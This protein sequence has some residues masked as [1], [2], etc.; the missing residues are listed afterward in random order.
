MRNH[1]HVMIVCRRF[2]PPWNDGIV[3]YAH[4]MTLLLT[5]L[6][7]KI[8]V[9]TDIWRCYLEVS[10]EDLDFFKCLLQRI[11]SYNILANFTF[12]RAN[13]IF[14]TSSLTKIIRIV[15]DKYNNVMFH[16]FSNATTLLPYVFPLV[17]KTLRSLRNGNGIHVIFHILTIPKVR[18]L[19]VINT[20][21]RQHKGLAIAVSDE[22][23]RRII[24][25]TCQHD[26]SSIWTLRPAIILPKVNLISGNIN[27]I[28][29]LNSIAGAHLLNV[30]HRD[31]I[32]AYVGPLKPHRFPQKIIV[33]ALRQVIDAG[34]DVSLVVATRDFYKR[35]KDIALLLKLFDKY[36]IKE[37]LYLIPRSLSEYEKALLYKSIDCLIQLYIG[38]PFDVVVPPLTILEAI[39]NDVPVITTNS[40]C[41]GELLQSYPKEYMIESK[42][43]NPKILAEKIVMAIDS[44]K[45]KIGKMYQKLKLIYSERNIIN[46]LTKLYNFLMQSDE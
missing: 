15:T 18:T 20:Y 41:L 36:N 26:Y 5:K 3:V 45:N 13:S 2:H 22:L 29:I 17:K 27:I 40:M 44:G 30:L 31:Y 16:I 39:F 8:H 32:I 23:L 9:L 14:R 25:A 12:K 37:R 34:Y 21:L 11:E 46:S 35:I 28:Q 10:Q 7:L 43:V 1:I 24:I 4:N 42:E 19:N 38:R 33:E 6:S